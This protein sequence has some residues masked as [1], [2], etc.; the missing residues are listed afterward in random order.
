MLGIG[1]LKRWSVSHVESL[2]AKDVGHTARKIALQEYFTSSGRA[3]HATPQLELLSESLQRPVIALEVGD[4][5]YGFSF[6]VLAVEYDVN[7]L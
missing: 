7:G 5:R 2:V 6:A 1:R 3:T 4:E